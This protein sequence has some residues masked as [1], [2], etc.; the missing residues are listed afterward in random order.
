MEKLLDIIV[1]CVL[2][3]MPISV[4][5]GAWIAVAKGAMIMLGGY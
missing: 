1:F 5:V 2:V 4:V 3:V